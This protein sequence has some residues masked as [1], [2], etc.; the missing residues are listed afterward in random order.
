MSQ[1]LVF[2]FLGHIFGSD[3][4]NKFTGNK[5]NGST[6]KRDTINAAFAKMTAEAVGVSPR[7]VKMV[8][9]AERKNQQVLETYMRI[10][11]GH[12]ILLE[13]VKKAVPF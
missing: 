8:L 1:N 3:M 12:N 9:S 4:Q 10:M 2:P 6:G 13:A 5:I 7:Y 11:E